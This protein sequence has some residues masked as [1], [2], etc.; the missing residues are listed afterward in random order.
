MTFFDDLVLFINFMISIKKPSFDG[1]SNITEFGAYANT[2]FTKSA[3]SFGLGPHLNNL[4]PSESK[5]TRIGILL[6]LFVKY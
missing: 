4:L 3:A 1:F 2:S 5:A 6:V